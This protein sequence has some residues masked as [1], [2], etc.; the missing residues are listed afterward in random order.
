MWNHAR[1]GVV[2]CY[3]MQGYPFFR[4]YLKKNTQKHLFDKNVLV[5]SQHQTEEH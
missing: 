2:S 4:C 1:K 3:I 5:I